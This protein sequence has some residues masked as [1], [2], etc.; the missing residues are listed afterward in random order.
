MPSNNLLANNHLANNLD[1]KQTGFTQVNMTQTGPR[2]KRTIDGDDL[3]APT[4][5]YSRVGGAG[6]G[7][8]LN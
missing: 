4:E 8:G 6:P 7:I 3:P 1:L 2:V 5:I